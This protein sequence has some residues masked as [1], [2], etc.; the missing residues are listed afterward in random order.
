VTD[1]SETRNDFDDNKVWNPFRFAEIPDTAD[2]KGKLKSLGLS[3]IFQVLSLERKS[4]VLHFIMGES[5]RAICFRDGKIT[6]ATGGQCLRLGYILCNKR[7]ISWDKLEEALAKARDSNKRLGEVLLDLG[8]ISNDILKSTV[9]F[10][11]QQNV[12]DLAS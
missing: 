6:A 5:G 11:I 1:Q 7:L 10:Q 9:R 2:L 12:S 3:G 4:G 8:L